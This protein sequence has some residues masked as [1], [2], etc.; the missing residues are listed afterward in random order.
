[1][2]IAST[3]ERTE[4]SVTGNSPVWSSG[5]STGRSPRRW[6]ISRMSIAAHAEGPSVKPN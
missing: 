3:I 5:S 2:P 6:P 4:S 1:M